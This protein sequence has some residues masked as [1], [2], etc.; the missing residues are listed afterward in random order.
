MRH[1]FKH[2]FHGQFDIIAR[3]MSLVGR[4]NFDQLGFGHSRI[5]HQAGEKVPIARMGTV[6]SATGTCAPVIPHH[7]R[8]NFSLSKAPSCVVAPV[9]PW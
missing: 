2:A 9:E 7:S 6:T 1:L 3:Q 8:L 4:E 5:T